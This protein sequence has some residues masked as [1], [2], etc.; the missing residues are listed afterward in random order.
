MLRLLALILLIIPPA[1]LP[2]AIAS[3]A[4][5]RDID[6]SSFVQQ[7]RP[8]EPPD[9]AAI[10][11][12][13]DK[14]LADETAAL[15]AARRAE[16]ARE[17]QLAAP[18]PTTPPAAAPAAIQAPGNC[19]GWIVAAGITDTIDAM[20]LIDKESGCNPYAVNPSSG[21]CGIAQELPCGK[22]GCTMG[23]G[24]CQLV[25]MNRYVLERYGSWASAVTFHRANNY[26]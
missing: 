22:S 15:E 10:K 6:V 11:R 17:A 4:P 8:D 19:S 9:Y 24:A 2:N 26:Y 14:R 3:P 12:A 5:S 20:W 18:A 23:D 21:A 25:W 16:K 7:P 1:Q 13:N